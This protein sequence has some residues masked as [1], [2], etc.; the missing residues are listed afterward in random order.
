MRTLLRVT[1]LLA[2]VL[3]ISVVA[4]SS[5]TTQKDAGPGE[6]IC[7]SNIIQATAAA[8]VE[9]TTGACHVEN[10][11]C[12]VGYLCGYFVQQAT[13]VC[14]GGTFKCTVD[15]P[16]HT[17]L[18]TPETDPNCAATVPISGGNPTYC[19]LCKST[20][21]DAGPETC[22]TDKT[23]ADGTSCTNAGQQCFYSNT[24]TGQPPPSDVCQCIGNATGDAGLM[25][26]CDLNTCP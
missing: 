9:G 11:T 12:V 8:G 22:P 3:C 26:R 25:W 13:C 7:P 19:E 23:K 18:D 17:A 15:N 24:C 16:D 5:D 10:Y 1:A 4:C 2:P 21:A 14:S 20:V 6:Q